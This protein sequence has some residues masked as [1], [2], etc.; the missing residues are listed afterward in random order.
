MC[1]YRMRQVAQPQ[2][3][4]FASSLNRVSLYVLADSH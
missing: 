2:K 1:N 3:V 4:L